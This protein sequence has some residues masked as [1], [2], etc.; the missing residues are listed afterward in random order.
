MSVYLAQGL[1]IL[2]LMPRYCPLG[3]EGTLTFPILP[4]ITIDY[5][6][7]ISISIIKMPYVIVYEG[8]LKLLLTRSKMQ[9][10]ALNLSATL[11]LDIIYVQSGRQRLNRLTV[12]FIVA[13]IRINIFQATNLCGRLRVTLVN[14]QYCS[15]ILIRYSLSHIIIRHLLLIVC[16]VIFVLIT[17][18]A[19]SRFA[20]RAWI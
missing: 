12:G 18:T 3:F 20:L 14:R 11:S 16:V 2:V 8:D 6:I 1:L 7:V 17:I 9:S 19:I 4:V 13:S 5:S 15:S 10:R